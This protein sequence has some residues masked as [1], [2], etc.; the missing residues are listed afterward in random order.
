MIGTRS[1][2]LELGVSAYMSALRSP[3]ADHILIIT[4]PPLLPPLLPMFVFVCSATV[5]AG[6]NKH[7]A[8]IQHKL[9]TSN[10]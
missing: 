7:R 1:S 3:A 8:S 2:A 9:N 10:N 5:S 4:V 6:D